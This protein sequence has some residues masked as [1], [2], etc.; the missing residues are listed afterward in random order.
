MSLVTVLKQHSFNDPNLSTVIRKI[1]VAYAVSDYLD[2]VH[3]LDSVHVRMAVEAARDEDVLPK[4]FDDYGKVSVNQFLT[5]S[6]TYQTIKF[7]DAVDRYI[8]NDRITGTKEIEWRNRSNR[9]NGVMNH[10]LLFYKDEDKLQ[11]YIKSR[12]FRMDEI[13]HIYRVNVEEWS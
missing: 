11:E 1:M 5:I 8:Q 12:I 10:L 3:V 13:H 4:Y 6:G 9:W 7:T 2:E